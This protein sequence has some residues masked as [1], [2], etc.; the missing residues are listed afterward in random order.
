MRILSLLSR[1]ALLPFALLVSEQAWAAH[2]VPSPVP[3]VVPT[4]S[5]EVHEFHDE[6]ERDFAV[7]SIAQLQVTNMRGDISIQGWSLDKIRIKARRKALASNAEEAKRLFSAVD[8]RH[9][10]SNSLIELAAEYGRG[11]SLEE[12]LREREHPRTSMEMTVFAP[13]GLKLKIWGVDGKILVRGWSASVDVRDSTGSINIESVKSGGA[14]VLCPSCAIRIRSVRGPVRSMGGSGN[15]ELSDVDS[16]L[17]YVETEA[18]SISASQVRG[19]QLYVTKS[20]PITA[21]E[22]SGRIEFHAGDGPVR[23]TDSSGFL[24]G[25]TTG[26]SIHAQ[27]RDWKFADKAVIE[28]VQGEIELKLPLDF[29]GEVDLK[30]GTGTTE[31]GFPVEITDERTVSRGGIVPSRSPGQITG[32]VG[33]GGELLKVSSTRGN[34]RVIGGG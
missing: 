13:A 26:G 6:I 34:V 1:F 14:S 4:E 16:R 3:S 29:S 23:I 30:S 15:I 33:E 21:R 8:F 20:G 28:S 31:L 7:R 24:S 18:G 2:P 11:L 25:R 9:Q 27:M 12:R 17:V 10:A 19:E 22:L 5:H 32:R